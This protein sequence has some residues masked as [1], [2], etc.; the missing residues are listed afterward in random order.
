MN[1]TILICPVLIIS[2]F[3]CSSPS[4]DD[5]YPV[6]KASLE[7]T[8]TSLYDIFEEIEIIPLETTDNSLLKSIRKVR[9]FDGKYYLLDG[10]MNRILFFDEK[11]NYINKID[12][13]GNG[14]GEYQ[15][16]NDF[17]LDEIN[18]QIEILAVL[19]ILQYNFDGSYKSKFTLPTSNWQHRSMDHL[20]EQNYVLYCSATPGDPI[21]KIVPRDESKEVKNLFYEN[22]YLNSLRRADAFSR[23]EK[24]NVYFTLPFLNEVFRV[25]PDSLE[26]AYVW[27]FGS[28]TNDISKHKSVNMGETDQTK[29]DEEAV[30]HLRMFRNENHP[31]IFYS[32]ANQFQTDAYYYAILT[33][34]PRDSKAKHLFYKKNTGEYI[35][36]EK[37]SEGLDIGVPLLVTNDYIIAELDYEKKESFANILTGKN[38]EI[39]DNSNEDD[40]SCLIKYTFQN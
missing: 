34:G 35:L 28:K 2:L 29:I 5:G 9:F 3:S 19:D 23:D 31:D 22:F 21:L 10:E 20:N 25:T 6:L 11:G 15:D 37:T 4:S 18:R 1:K 16:I 38:K 40:N 39:I 8:N 32:F 27:D 26:I 7:D 36:F 17:Y 30:A 12:A 14:P 13:M 24:G 33:F